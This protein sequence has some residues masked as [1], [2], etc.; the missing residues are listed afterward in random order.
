MPKHNSIDIHR[1]LAK[2]FHNSQNFEITDFNINQDFC[3]DLIKIGSNHL[4]LPAIFG[5]IRRK[6]IQI[7]FPKDFLDYLKEISDLNQDRNKAILNQIVFISKIFN[8]NQ[9]KHVFVKGSAILL[10]RKINELSERMLGD[11]DIL[12]SEQDLKNAYKILLENGFSEVCDEF[13]FVG[14]IINNKHLNRI[15]HPDY[16]A[17]VE[18]HRRLLD[19][20]KFNLIKPIDVLSSKKQTPAGFWVP[21][22]EHLWLHA[23]LN[24][25]YNDN[26]FYYNKF[27]FRSFLDVVFLDPENKKNYLNK[28][29]SVTHFYSLCS[30][31]LHQ[32]KNS[33][34]L[35]TIFFKYKLLYP[36]FDY[37]INLMTKF[38][39]TSRIVFNRLILIMRS[40]T[41]RNRVIENPRLVLDRS[42]IFFRKQ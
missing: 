6:K 35:S 23:I 30:V 39:I 9:V 36:K 16:V 21:S 32:Y 19:N 28:H 26:G 34:Y 3:D 20:P 22:N 25:Q 29:P 13:N 1:F 31:F 27:S 11:I 41:Y 33:N 5:A 38:K 4:V 37:I 17:S 12:I 42:L 2:L 10:S 40:K 15:A 14:D 24:W 18:L 8:K 7:Y